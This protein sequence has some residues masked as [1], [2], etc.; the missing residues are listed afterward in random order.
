M[1]FQLKI[2]VSFRFE[3]KVSI[4]IHIFKIFNPIQL[5]YYSPTLNMMKL[6]FMTS[7][8][9]EELLKSVSDLKSAN[10][11]D[12]HLG[13]SGVSRDQKFCDKFKNTHCQVDHP[14]KIE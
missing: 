5:R 3:P 1:T 8:H 4:Q 9:W 6:S 10:T 11:A 7:A 13:V 2:R 12:A 14:A